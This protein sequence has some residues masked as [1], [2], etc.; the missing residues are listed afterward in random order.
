[1]G[2]TMKD[3]T[4]TSFGLMIAYLLPGLAGLY[5]LSFW[6]EPVRDCLSAFLMAN[7]NV[8]LFLLVTFVAIGL[9]LQITVLRWL[10]FECIFCRRHSLSARDYAALGQESRLAAFRVSVDEHYRY[11]QFWGGI[12]VVLPFLFCGTRGDPRFASLV[13]GWSGLLIYILIQVLTII[14]AIVSFKRYTER[15]KYILLGDENYAKW[16]KKEGQKEEGEEKKGKKEE[17]E[18]EVVGKG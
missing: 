6:C 15:S 13:A 14:A 17:G 1:M 11:H 16:N 18:E 5:A 9:G 8:G 7:S 10:V 2:S 12:T 4:S 3:I